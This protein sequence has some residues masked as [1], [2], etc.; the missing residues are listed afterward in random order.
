MGYLDDLE[1]DDALPVGKGELADWWRK[2]QARLVRHLAR[3]PL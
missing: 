1:Q 2:R 3:N